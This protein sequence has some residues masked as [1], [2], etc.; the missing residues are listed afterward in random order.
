MKW[1][2]KWHETHVE[3]AELAYR[4]THYD[5]EPFWEF[6]VHLD[7]TRLGFG[8]DAE[9]EYGTPSWADRMHFAVVLGPLT[10][11]A[12]RTWNEPHFRGGGES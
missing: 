6:S 8:V 2:R 5:R 10:L 12:V 1:V 11:G 3:G 9:R 7:W 4:C